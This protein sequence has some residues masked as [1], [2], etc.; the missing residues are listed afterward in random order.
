MVGNVGFDTTANST[1]IEAAKFVNMIEYRTV[2]VTSLRGFGV[3]RHLASGVVFVV[4]HG[5]RW[6]CPGT[7]LIVNE[8]QSSNVYLYH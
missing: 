8:P 6:V 7:V 5:D 2:V 4:I 1:V 3:Q